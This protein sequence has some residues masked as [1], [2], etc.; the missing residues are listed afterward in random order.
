MDELLSRD[1]ATS[2][3]APTENSVCKRPRFDIP[4]QQI[5]HLASMSFTW[6]QIDEILGV[7]R[8]TVYRRC[9]EYGLQD[10]GRENISDEELRSLVLHLQQ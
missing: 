4:R 7:S 5:V 6:T 9:L 2:Y 10:Y 1:M 8:S 3:S